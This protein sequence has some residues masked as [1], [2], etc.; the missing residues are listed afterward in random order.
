METPGCLS[1]R[2]VPEMNGT[3]KRI[4]REKAGR[5]A[6]WLAAWYLRLKGYHILEQRFRC[7]DG[8][9]DIVARRKSDLVIVEVKQRATRDLAE[10]SLTPYARRRISRAADTYVARNRHVQQLAVRFDAVFIIGWRQIIHLKDAWR[11]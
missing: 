9:I 10:E 6:E 7:P 5:R 1:T 2:P 8:E 4:R 3:S 11:D